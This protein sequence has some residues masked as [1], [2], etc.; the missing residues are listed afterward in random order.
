MA[1]EQ[2]TDICGL[3]GEPGADKIPHPV[4]WPGERR[5]GSEFVHA[6][7]EDMACIEAWG[8]LSETEREMFLRTIK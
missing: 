2:D 4:Y 5:P 6:D 3:C 7:C 1:D 8:L